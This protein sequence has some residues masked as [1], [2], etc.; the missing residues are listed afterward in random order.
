M[1]HHFCEKSIIMGFFDY[2]E[3]L[4]LIPRYVINRPGS[5]KTVPSTG[6]I[7]IREF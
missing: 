3:Y 4:S 2:R 7:T 5:R 6:R 1:P